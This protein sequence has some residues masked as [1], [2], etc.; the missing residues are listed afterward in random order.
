M[1]VISIFVPLCLII[2]SC[3]STG[4]RG[5][6]INLGLTDKFSNILNAVAG[7]FNKPMRS[8]LMAPPIKGF[9]HTQ[10][11]NPNVCTEEELDQHVR[12][13][14]GTFEGNYAGSTTG[15]IR[16]E[17]IDGGRIIGHGTANGRQFKLVGVSNLITGPIKHYLHI[18]VNAL[19]QEVKFNFMGKIKKDGMLNTSWNGTIMGQSKRGQLVLQKTAPYKKRKVNIAAKAQASQPQVRRSKYG[20]PL[21]TNNQK[22]FDAAKNGKTSTIRKLVHAGYDLAAVDASGATAFCIALKNHNRSA[23]QSLMAFG[24]D[25]AH[26]DN[27]GQ[28]PL[29]YAAIYNDEIIAGALVISGAD[30]TVKDNFGKTP[31]DW[32]IEKGNLKVVNMMDKVKPMISTNQ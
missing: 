12:P 1:R 23:A 9:N 19:D 20:K 22:L 21:K 10:Q 15:T 2:S 18:T 11:P 28:T 25:S 27:N 32:A 4:D 16:F 8:C 17:I 30:V 7:G 6:G 13:L 3:A 5:I 26:K 14:F 31:R 24:S 29:H